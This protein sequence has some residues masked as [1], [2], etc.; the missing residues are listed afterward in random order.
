MPCVAHLDVIVGAG[1]VGVIFYVK[2][3]IKIQSDRETLL[4]L[5]SVE[6]VRAFRVRLGKICTGDES[7]SL[8]VHAV[9]A[10]H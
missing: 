9:T 6:T 10:L 3:I 8:R 7:R 1:D 2:G 5:D 4:Q